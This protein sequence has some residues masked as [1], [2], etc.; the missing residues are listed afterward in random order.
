MAFGLENDDIKLINSVF[1]QYPQIEKVMIYGSRAKG[2]YRPGSDIDLALLGENMNLSLQLE[3]ENKLD[4]LLLPYKMDIA[5][6][7]KIEN[8]DLLQHIERVAKVF[9]EKELS[10]KE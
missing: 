5:L 2:K 9:Y 10:S 7:H 4:D 6:L 8:R 3:L 1:A